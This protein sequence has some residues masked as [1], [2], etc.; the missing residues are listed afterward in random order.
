MQLE[1][2]ILNTYFKLK[3]F[4]LIYNHTEI[5]DW[6]RSNIFTAT[7]SPGS[8]S[9]PL[10]LS[11]HHQQRQEQQDQNKP[12][13]LTS[14]HSFAKWLLQSIVIK[15]CAELW[16]ISVLMKLDEQTSSLSVSHMKLLLEQ[17]DAERSNAYTNRMANLLLANRHWSTELMIESLWWSLGSATRDNN[18]KKIHMRGSPFFLGV[19]LIKLSSYGNAT[20]LD[21]SIHTLRTEY[22]VCLA[23]FLMKL[24]E[25]GRLYGIR[26]R[27]KTIVPTT[28]VKSDVVDSPTRNVLSTILVNAKIT[29]ITSFLFNHHEACILLSL[30]EV[31]LARTQ[32]ITVL[33]MDGF[34]TAILGVVTEQSLMSLNDFTDVFSNVKVIRIEYMRTGST[35]SSSVGQPQF[36]IYILNDTE[37]MWNPN[38]HMHVVTLCRDVSALKDRI[39]PKP[40]DVVPTSGEQKRAAA[41][42]TAAGPLPMFDVYAEGNTVLGIKMSE[43]HSMQLFVSN[44][45]MNRKEAG[46]CLIS[47][48]KI[49]IN[50]DEMHIFTLKDIDIQSAPSVDVLRQE[51]QNYDHFV[52]VCFAFVFFFFF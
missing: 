37:A 41:A 18:L 35:A 36:N 50:I 30:A 38:L 11:H 13:A 16:N 10:T 39:M 23:S 40:I 7:T 6:M 33:K 29:D 19:S 42:S 25:C 51:R 9:K 47:M 48:E 46:K 24:V 20:K 4:Q 52:L 12:T 15:G 27:E 43:R 14:N 34:Q 31:T 45:Y 2:D 26:K 17:Y 8:A 3:T 32:Q 1:Q 44:F 22:S 21:L 28:V 5:Y 49:F